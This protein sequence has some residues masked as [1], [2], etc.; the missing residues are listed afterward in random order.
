MHFGFALELSNIDLWNIDSRHLQDM[1]SR[2]LQDVLSVTTFC[3]QGRPEDVLK[4]SS[5]R[6]AT[7]TLKTC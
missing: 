6:Y 1:P 7:V 2:R 4:T 3:L 5:R